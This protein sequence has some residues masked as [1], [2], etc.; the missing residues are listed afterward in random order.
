MC[1]VEQK[2]EVT[3]NQSSSNNNN[4]PKS[5]PITKCKTQTIS[6]REKKE[7]K[8]MFTQFS[9]TMT[10]VWKRDLF[11]YLSMNSLKRDTK[12]L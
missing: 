10:F 11:A 7:K 5:N 12:E 2:K 4:I 3:N 1:S 9:P 8:N 6:K